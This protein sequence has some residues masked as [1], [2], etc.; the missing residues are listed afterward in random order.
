M[1]VLVTILS[2]SILGLVFLFF[3]KSRELFYGN[4]FLKEFKDRFDGPVV[5]FEMSLRYAWKNFNIRTFFKKVAV[6]VAYIIHILLE[7]IGKGIS[8]IQNEIQH[9]LALLK[10]KK[11]NVRKTAPSFFIKHIVKYKEKLEEEKK[12]NLPPQI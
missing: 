3:I 12:K 6:S 1:I 7:L 4:D 2:I 5:V 10:G 11:L 9:L 8:L